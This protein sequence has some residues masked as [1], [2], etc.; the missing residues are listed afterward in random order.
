MAWRSTST[1]AVYTRVFVHQK[2]GSVGVRPGVETLWLY[3]IQGTD[4]SPLS[5]GTEAGLSFIAVDWFFCCLIYCK[6]FIVCWI[7]GGGLLG[8]AT[9]IKWA[10]PHI[11][12]IA[13]TSTHLPIDQSMQF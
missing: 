10:S 5:L 11:R 12:T 4:S 1:G 2:K 6:R 13:V 3:E 7:C 9:H 8:D